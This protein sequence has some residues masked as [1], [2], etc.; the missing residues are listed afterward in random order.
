MRTCCRLDPIANDPERPCIL[1]VAA[2]LI[3]D[4]AWRAAVSNSPGRSVRHF[5]PTGA[6]YFEVGN[7]PCNDILGRKALRRDRY[8]KPFG[9]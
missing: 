8:S 7:P 6:R 9:N 2:H 5:N 3:V 1:L 4:K